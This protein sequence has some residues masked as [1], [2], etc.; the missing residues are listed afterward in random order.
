MRVFA[1]SEHLHTGHA[2][3]Q[4]LGKGA[5]VPLQVLG[6]GGV[7]QGHVLEGFAGQALSFLLGQAVGTQLLGYPVVVVRVD[8][9]HHVGEVLGCGPDHGRAAYVYV[10]QRLLQGDA[11][12]GD[13]LPEWVEVADHQV[14]GLDFV[15]GQLCQVIGQVTS[16]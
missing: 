8:D 1:V 9:H 2:H 13:G 14:N 10:F 7:V 5:V 16:G 3:R 15:L 12:P 4:L 6:D 11:G